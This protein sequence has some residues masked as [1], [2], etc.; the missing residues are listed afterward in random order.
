MPNILFEYSGVKNKPFKL[1]KDNTFTLSNGDTIYIPKGYLT[2][3]ASVPT[4]LRIF[5]DHI[6]A[7]YVAFI[8]HDYLYNFAGYY[9]N[10]KDYT[11]EVNFKRV[12]RKFADKEMRFFQRSRG[13]SKLRQF[14]YYWGVRLGG[15]LRFNKI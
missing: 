9:T 6:G 15:V 10:E 7:D 14:V 13:A 2:D 11:R 1:A 8:I 5:T 3:F 12:S 4:I